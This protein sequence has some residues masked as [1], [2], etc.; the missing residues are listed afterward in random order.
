MQNGNMPETSLMGEHGD[1]KCL[2]RRFLLLLKVFG[3]GG[4]QLLQFQSWDVF[5]FP[6]E[7]FSCAVG[8]FYQAP[9]I[10]LSHLDCVAVE[11]NGSRTYRMRFDLS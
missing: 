1:F 3:K 11:P 7:D 9:N 4:N 5:S 10:F 2:H 8:T 6:L